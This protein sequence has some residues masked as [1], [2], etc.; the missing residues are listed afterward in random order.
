M[1]RRVNLS[2]RLLKK[3][4]GLTFPIG[5]DDDD[6]GESS[7]VRTR[8]KN[9]SRRRKIERERLENNERRTLMIKMNVAH[10]DV[11]ARSVRNVHDEMMFV[12]F[13]PKFGFILS[14]T[15]T[16]TNNVC[17]SYSSVAIRCDRR[18]SR[19]ESVVEEEI[20]KII[21]L[22]VKSGVGVFPNAKSSGKNQS[23]TKRSGRRASATTRTTTRTTRRGGRVL[24]TPACATGARERRDGI[25]DVFERFESRVRGSER[26]EC[27]R[28]V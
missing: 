17:E 19:G 4:I 22:V 3:S 28:G 2:A 1:A 21:T 20:V 15:T 27:R 23:E 6:D 11:L 10:L 9:T 18:D 13:F 7:V 8:A 12:T 24:R 5:D 26:V 14:R 25:G 16:N